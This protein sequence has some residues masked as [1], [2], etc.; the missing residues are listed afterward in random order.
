M[1]HFFRKLVAGY[2]RFCARRKLARVQ[3][4]IIAITGSVGK[5][6]TKDAMYTVLSSKHTAKRST[7]NFNTEFGVPLTILNQTSSGVGFFS[8]LWIIFKSFFEMFKK[9]DYEFLILEMGIDTPGDMDVLVKIVQPHVSVM[10]RVIEA[11]LD[12]GQFPD[13]QSIFNEK[14]KLVLG[15]DPKGIAIL[16]HDDE[17]IKHFGESYSGQI[18]WY[19]TTPS[20]DLYVNYVDQNKDGLSGEVVFRGKHVPFSWP[21]LGKHHMTVLLPAIACGLMYDLTLE[22]CVEALRNFSLPPGRMNLIPGLHDTSIIDSSYNASPASVSAALQVL[23]EVG[24][25]QRRIAVLGSMNELGAIAEREHR[26]IGKIVGRYADILVAVGA[27]ARWIAEE[28]GLSG[29]PTEHI[30]TFNDAD[31]AADYLK[32]QL[33]DHDVVLV[34]GSQNN[35]RLERLVKKIMA[36]PA[37]A[38]EL[39]VRQS[40]EWHN[41]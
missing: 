18:I 12:P 36:D 17:L 37:Q 14:K 30:R 1:R 26:K 13:L 29:I 24:K 2:L 21:I 7:K 34:K 4:R 15:M 16:N 35:V 6:S 8:W 38:S 27:S 40:P 23:S 5:T 22:E 3:P 10:T 9:D 39:L 31:E 25:G 41:I 11:H 32:E 33:A 19:G 20:A 28:A